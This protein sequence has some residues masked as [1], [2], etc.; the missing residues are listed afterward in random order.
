V[1]ALRRDWI[2]AALVS[3]ATPFAGFFIFRVNHPAI[4]SVCY[5][6]WLLWAWVRCIQAPTVRATAAGAGVWFVA[7]W[8]LLAS[9]TV[10]E[11]YMLLASLNAAGLAAFVFTRDPVRLQLRKAAVL[12]VAGAA[13]LLA[14]MP[15]W[16]IFADALV[17]SHSFSDQPAAYRIPSRLL[18]GFFDDLFYR[19]LDGSRRIF[20]PSGN[21]L[22]FAGVLW[23]F[24]RLRLQLVDPLVRWLVVG[25][26]VALGLAVD[27]IPSAWV[28]S[29]PG[30]RSVGHLHNTFSCVALV[31]FAVLAGC[32]FAA[33]RET[34]ALPARR[35]LGPVA[36]LCGVPAWLLWQYFGYKPEWWHTTPSVHGWIEKIPEHGFFYAALL[37]SIAGL[38]VL[39]GAARRA[40]RTGTVSWATGGATAIVLLILLAP[41][42][43]QLPF[44]FRAE[45]FLVPPIR[46]NLQARSPV[47]DRLRAE[48]TREPFR[49]AG[50]GATLMPDFGAFH[51]LETFYGVDALWNRHYHALMIAS[52][53]GRNDD[54]M[55][56][57]DPEKLAA[58]R[59]FFDLLNVKF[60]VSPLPQLP[61]GTG[62]EPVAALDL[63][64]FASPTTWP[65]AF[66]TDAVVPYR[67]VHE[68]VEIARANPGRPFAAVLESDLPRVGPRV[69]RR[70]GAKPGPVA[71]ASD[72]RLTPNSTSFVVEATGP[73]II[74]LHEA[75][76]KEDFRVTVNGV[77]TPYFRVNHAFKGIVVEKAGTYR[78]TFR[79]WPRHLTTALA[80]SA[81]GFAL[82]AAGAWFVR[83]QPDPA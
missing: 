16:L 41:H 25:G 55:W 83:R 53:L 4:F 31:F 42:G 57:V 11:A 80:C 13:L 60:C 81:A 15:L 63:S 3:F 47:L 24:A 9:G 17:Q 74:A 79:Y 75:W 22:L 23:C 69:A 77:A 28:L 58:Q 37:A 1:F 27:W 39:H 40:L 12:A 8:C 70:T 46:A 44:D 38:V 18:I 36:V 50:T 76:M 52:G 10:K 48:T 35:L 32:G 6:P 64:I 33:A 14:S 7:N 5:A 29:I 61:P 68:V 45:Y 73:G 19:E 62:Y 20:C 54:W 51:G 43:L 21:L 59:P 49:V 30:L 65:R 71:R 34:L 67:G 72:Y 2:A 78:V 26:L 82:L 56:G 66:F